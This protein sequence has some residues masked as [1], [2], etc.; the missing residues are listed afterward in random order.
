MTLP[1][2][3]AGRDCIALLAERRSEL[4]T[5]VHTIL[6]TV[7]RLVTD[8]PDEA[9]EDFT[10]DIGNIHGL[11]TSLRDLVTDVLTPHKLAALETTGDLRRTMRHDLLNMLNGVLMCSDLWIEELASTDDR[12][13][14]G[15]LEDFQLIHSAARKCEK[16][17]DSLL[18]SLV[19]GEG[20]MRLESD[21]SIGESISLDDWIPSDNLID[22]DTICGRVLIIDDDD[23]SRA[24]LDRQLNVEGHAVITAADGNAGWET[25]RNNDDIDIVLLDIM[26]PGISG[27]ELL[28]RMKNDERLRPIPVIMISALDE[29]DAV[30]QC[31]KAGADDYLPKPFNRVLLNARIR[32]SLQRRRLEQE[33]LKEKRR[34]DELLG[35]ILPEDIVAELKR[36]NHVRPRRHD[37]VAV[38][39]ADI[40]NF[41]TY[42]EGHSPQHVLGRLQELVVTWEESAARYNVEKIKTIGDAFMAAAGLSGKTELAVENCVR[43]GIEMIEATRALGI[44]WDLRVGVHVG[45][46]VAGVLGKCKYAFD[47]WGDTVNTASRME[48]HGVPGSIVLSEQATAFV[49]AADLHPQPLGSM[50]VKGKG[51][52]EAFRIEPAAMRQSS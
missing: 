24:A 27:Y 47:L 46:V 37:Q 28:Q 22:D 38:L 31:V 39:F 23:I 17:V 13:L 2:G 26:M 32:A 19:D 40:V 15:Y 16:L 4:L 51:S 48:S 14:V 33:I 25:L 43:C 12:F 50:N 18:N 9:P 5:P 21:T 11:A 45:P 7:D 30:V 44:G 20:Q 34:S 29:I 35:V 1:E 41:T 10:G 8:C 49:T 6:D 42:C 36:A 3:S 52:V